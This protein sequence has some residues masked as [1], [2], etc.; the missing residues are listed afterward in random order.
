M[1][2]KL[3]K[4]TEWESEDSDPVVSLETWASKK[5][6]TG[7]N[8]YETLERTRWGELPPWAAKGMAA[9]ANQFKVDSKMKYCQIAVST[10][11]N[12]PSSDEV[13]TMMFDGKRWVG[14]DLE[15]PLDKLKPRDLKDETTG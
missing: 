8:S 9:L 12:P 7:E 11:R 2:A 10:S 4:K 14:Y 15:Q 1:K 3:Q 13:K 6:N 5:E